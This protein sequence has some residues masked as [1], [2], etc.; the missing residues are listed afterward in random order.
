MHNGCHTPTPMP[1][2]SGI[3]T[4]LGEIRCLALYKYV[5]D[6]EDYYGAFLC[7]PFGMSSDA[8]LGP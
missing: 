6:G 3:V 1:S 8:G 7:G 2:L 5:Y 4:K